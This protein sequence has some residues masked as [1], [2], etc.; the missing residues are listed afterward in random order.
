VPPASHAEALRRMRH[1][2]WEPK[3]LDIE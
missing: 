3:K 2:Q 1:R